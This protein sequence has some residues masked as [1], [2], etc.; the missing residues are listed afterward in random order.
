MRTFR[1]ISRCQRGL[2]LVELLVA[3]SILSV[4]MVALSMTVM[5]IM[6]ISPLSRD[7][8]VALEE[9]QN[10]GYYISRDVQSARLINSAP[11]SPQFLDLTVPEWDDTTGT[12]VDRTVVYKFED[13]EDGLKR[14]VRIYDFPDGP[15][16][17]IAESIYYNPDAD[18]DNSTGAI[19]SS[20]NQTLTLK[21]TTMT[22]DT[23]I[24]QKEYEA[25]QRV[26]LDAE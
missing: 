18:P 10:A 2:T 1:D 23:A 19:C 26:P 9:N 7:W 20:D 17:L 15:Q 8:A 16:T 24:V 13:M 21:I 6:R 11:T 3:I 12:V 4:I 14:L 22:S 25:K 5:T